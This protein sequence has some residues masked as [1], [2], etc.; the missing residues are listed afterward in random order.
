MARR[1]TL[2]AEAA[3]LLL[4]ARKVLRAKRAAAA[5]GEPYFD[6]SKRAPLQ[7]GAAAKMVFEESPA[8]YEPVLYLDPGP[9]VG[10]EDRIAEELLGGPVSCRNLSPPNG[11]AA[12]SVFEYVRRPADGQ[13]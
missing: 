2:E 6:V 7:C 12:P 5:E 3:F 13:A 9:Y 11:D 10:H 8:G 1:I 4:V